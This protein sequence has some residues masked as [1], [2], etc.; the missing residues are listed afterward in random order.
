MGNP[1]KK[2]KRPDPVEVARA[3]AKVQQEIIAEQEAAAEAETAAAQAKFA[4][5]EERKRQLSRRGRRRL[6]ATPYGYLGDQ[7]EFGGS[8]SLLT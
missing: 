5:S 3:Q 1:F 7:S 4:G 6:I 2:P 8:G